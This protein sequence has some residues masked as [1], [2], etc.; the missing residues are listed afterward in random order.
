MSEYRK[1]SCEWCERDSENWWGRFVGYDGEWYCDKHYRQLKKHGRVIDKELEQQ[2]L[3]R[4]KK[5]EEKEKNR[6]IIQGIVYEHGI[7]DT[8]YG[9]SKENKWNYMLY[10]KWQGMLERVYSEKCHEKQPTYIN[11]TLQLEWHWLSK[12]AEDFVKLDGYDEEKFL[13]GELELDK[14]IKSNGKNK[15]YSLENC[16][17]IS[18]SENT[19]Q[20]VSTRNNNYMIGENNWMYGKGYLRWGENSGRFK[21]IVQLDLDM[22]LIETF[23]G[24]GEINRKYN[25]C[26]SSIHKCCKGEIETSKGYIWMYKDAYDLYQQL[27]E[28]QEIDKK[29]EYITNK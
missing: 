19:R 15:E 26:P 7:N 18:K 23:N 22:N 16:M 4:L 27:N 6:K 29:L 12:F 13:N 25:Y 24:T 2:E 10:T 14:D 28:L 1:C 8:P 3:E 17:L 9:W 5:K 21:K 20:A 11:S